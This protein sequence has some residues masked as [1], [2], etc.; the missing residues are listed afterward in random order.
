MDLTANLGVEIGFTSHCRILPP[1]VAKRLNASW[2]GAVIA[3]RQAQA[4]VVCSQGRKKQASTGWPRRILKPYYYYYCEG[5]C[6]VWG[7]RRL[8]ELGWFWLHL[9]HKGEVAVWRAR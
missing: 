7:E 3:N 2:C 9:L 1:C 4:G 6:A 8:R 5:L